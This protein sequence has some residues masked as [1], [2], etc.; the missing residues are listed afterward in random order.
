MPGLIK[1]SAPFITQW[2]SHVAKRKGHNMK[3]ISIL[4]MQ[5]PA[6]ARIK[7]RLR[8]DVTNIF[9]DTSSRM[10]IDVIVL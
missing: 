6:G 4:T 9:A 10:A 3:S 2:L 8:K 7:S 5:A 1:L